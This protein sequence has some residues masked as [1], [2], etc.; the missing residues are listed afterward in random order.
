MLVQV[1]LERSGPPLMHNGIEKSP[2]ASRT[3]RRIMF[4]PEVVLQLYALFPFF[5]CV[6]GSIAGSERFPP[7]LPLFYLSFTK[8]LPINLLH[9]Y[10]CI[11]AWFSEDQTNAW[12]KERG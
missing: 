4:S 5:S 6:V 10:T 3:I 7:L 12:A 9:V 2:P 8:D 1:Y 11:S